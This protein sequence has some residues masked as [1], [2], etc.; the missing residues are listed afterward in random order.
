M[1]FYRYKLEYGI[2]LAYVSNIQLLYSTQKNEIFNP[3]NCYKL[4]VDLPYI[5]V[6][7]THRF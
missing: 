5:R 1:F 7:S 6:L 3:N 2:Q 4:A